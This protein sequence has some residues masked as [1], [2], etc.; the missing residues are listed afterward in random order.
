VFA[1]RRDQS[2][3]AAIGAPA[4]CRLRASDLRDGGDDFPRYPDSADDLVS[5]HVVGNQSEER[6]QCP[7][8]TASLGLGELP[9]GLGL[10]AQNCGG[11][12]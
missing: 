9:D 6:R 8:A 2:L 12:W 4:V 5:R 11:P 10:A 7:G 3:A 1:L